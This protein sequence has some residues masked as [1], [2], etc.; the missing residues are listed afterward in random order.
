MYES[1]HTKLAR[2]P[3][4]TLLF[5]GHLYA[6][7]PSSSIGEQ[8]QMNPFLRVARLEDFLAFMGVSTR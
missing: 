5:P 1:L 3:D 2:L 8:K 7:E 6:P 4:E